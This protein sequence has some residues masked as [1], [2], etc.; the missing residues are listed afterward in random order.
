MPGPGDNRKER[1]VHRGLAGVAAAGLGAGHCSVGKHG[2]HKTNL[3]ESRLYTSYAL[4][5]PTA[6]SWRMT[7]AGIL[8]DSLQLCRYL[9]P[10][11][12]DLRTSTHPPKSRRCCRKAVLR[13]PATPK[14]PTLK[15]L[16]CTNR[17]IGMCFGIP[18]ACL[19]LASR[20]G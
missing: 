13:T 3:W 5:E 20:A 1:K 17:E 6:L 19:D 7:R 8:Q 10:R 9:A 11:L 2:R 15:D 4:P 16:A 14:L 12:P 18:G